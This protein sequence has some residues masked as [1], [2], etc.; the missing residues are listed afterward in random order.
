MARR[1]LE[2][3][4][5]AVEAARTPE[6]A[7]RCAAGLQEQLSRL[8]DGKENG[9]GRPARAVAMRCFKAVQQRLANL[10][11]NMLVLHKPG[12]T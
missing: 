4:I 6:D 11:N 3:L 7:Q 5:A 8:G 12:G 2:S 10:C 9:G 1:E